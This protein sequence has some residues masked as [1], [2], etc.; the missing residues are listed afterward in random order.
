MVSVVSSKLGSGTILLGRGP[1]E[2]DEL[3]SEVLVLEELRLLE[4]VVIKLEV[5]VGSTEDVDELDDDVDEVEEISDELDEELEVVDEVEISKLDE[6]LDEVEV[7]E[8][9]DV[10]DKE[11]EVVDAML[12]V[13]VTTAGAQYW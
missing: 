5:I 6:E 11:L 9:S 13:L 12:Q 7:E 4:L 1:D 8:T 3:G 10:L 2:H